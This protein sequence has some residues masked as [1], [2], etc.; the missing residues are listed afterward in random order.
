LRIA[1]SRGKTY[2]ECAETFGCSTQIVNYYAKKYD[3]VNLNKDS[4]VQIER[5]RNAL[6]EGKN[7]REC[8]EILGWSINKITYNIRKY[9]LGKARKNILT[10]EKLEYYLMK[11][12]PAQFATQYDY[13]KQYIY[14]RMRAF[15]IKANIRLTSDEKD[16][17]ILKTI[18][19][20]SCIQFEELINLKILSRAPLSKSIQRIRDRGLIDFGYTVKV[21][22]F[23]EKYRSRPLMEI[24]QR[25]FNFIKNKPGISVEELSDDLGI[26]QEGVLK[27]ATILAA[28]EVIKE[29]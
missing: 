6:D 4:E 18:R 8:A 14:S 27:L 7:Y 26:S 28:H 10:K 19:E 21:D 25:L 13:D 9:N 22:C 12:T 2:R 16:D 20:K 24:E 29:L 5:L 15:G 17:R 23:D 3:L 11:M 1:L